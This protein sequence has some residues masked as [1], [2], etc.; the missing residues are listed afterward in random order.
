[1]G[2]VG[3]QVGNRYNAYV[4]SFTLSL[5]LRMLTLDRDTA[6]QYVANAAFVSNLLSSN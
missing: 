6:R 2:Q 1:M 5:G 4:R 3:N